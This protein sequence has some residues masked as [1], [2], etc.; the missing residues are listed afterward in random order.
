MV[1]F[2][3]TLME[4]FPVGLLISLISAALLRKNEFLPSNSH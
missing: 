4:I 1:R 2:G 3:M